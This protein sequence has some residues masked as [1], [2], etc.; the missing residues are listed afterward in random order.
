MSGKLKSHR[1]FR[2][3]VTLAS[4]SA[5]GQLIML[6]A[7]PFLTRLYTP[8]DFGVFAVFSALMSVVLVISSLRY[9][10][11]IPLPQSQKSASRLLVIA[12]AIN[13]VVALMALCIVALFRSK[14]AEWAETPA[15]ET[16][17][18]LLPLAII[19]GGTYKALN[20]WAIRNKGYQ[21]IAITKL[22]QSISNVLAQM[23]GG[24]SGVGG[25]GLIL[26][27]VI[28]Q[29][30]GITR[31]SKGLSIRNL[32]LDTSRK[33]SIA[34]LAR[35]RK[36]PKYD[37]PAAG[38]NALSAQLS[39]VAMA[40]V[41]GPVAAGLFYLADRILAVPMSVISQSISQVFLGQAKEDIA[42]GQFYKRVRN[43]SIYLTAI[44]SVVSILTMVL[45]APVF[46]FLFGESW[47]ASGLFASWLVWGLSMQ[48]IYSP[49]S[50]VLVA[51]E[52]QGV[53][54]LIHCLILSLK[55]LVFIVS[56]LVGDQ[57]VAVKLLSLSLVLGYG[58]GLFVVI[59]S[60]RNFDIS[61]CSDT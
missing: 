20:F 25:I 15:L 39:N 50:M 6:A 33:H 22:T 29:S 14:I 57:L 21:K 59:R 36:F 28:G 60:A 49:L 48:F 24:V 45:A 26:G 54:F 47:H 61:K 42:S 46:Q 38:V 53:N 23:L 5:G 1:F 44:A 34:L 10:L 35:Y 32:R 56:G 12:L 43:V 31:L 11:A 17:L 16:F 55:I 3:V 27:Q 8:E 9:E 13:L 2:A 51:T 40:V 30:V 19:T 52:R 7:I 58:F 18:W 4:A 37:V 41:F